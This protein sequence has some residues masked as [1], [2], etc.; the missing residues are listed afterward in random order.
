MADEKQSQPDPD[1]PRRAGGPGGRRRP[2]KYD[3]GQIRVLDDVE[4][5]RTRPGMYIGGYNAARAAPPRL[6]NRRQLDRRSAGRATAK[7]HPGE[8]QRRRLVHGHRRRPRHSRRHPPDRGHPDRRGRLRHPRRRRQVRARRRPAPTRCPAAC[9]ASARR[10][11]TS[12]ANGSRSKSAATARS[13]TWSSSAATRP[14]TSRSSARP[15][16]TGTKVTLQ[17]RPHALPRR[18]SFK[19]TRRSPTACASW[20]TSTRASQIAFEDERTGKRDDVQVRG[21]PRRVRRATSTRARA[22]LHDVI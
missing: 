3:E 8:D 7:Q 12:S 9:T 13:T 21:R 18:P 17:A 14:P 5:V 6:R 2:A 4:H 20:R 10:S 1:R 16:K 19:S 22:T 11:S 15:A